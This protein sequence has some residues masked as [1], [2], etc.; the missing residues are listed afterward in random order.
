MF[1]EVRNVR[2]NHLWKIAA[3]GG[4]YMVAGCSQKE[5]HFA[6]QRQSSWRDADP[7]A[8]TAA[9]PEK[10][11]E[12]LPQTH[13]AAAH[14]FEKQGNMQRAVVQ[15]QKALQIDPN[16]LGALNRLGVVYSRLGR[17]K[18]AEAVLIRAVELDPS[19]PYLRNN[20]G[21][22][23]V[24]QKR[25]QDAEA[26]FRNALSLKPDFGRARINMGMAL[27]R[28]DRY[29]DAMQQF[30]DVVPEPDAYYNLGLMMRAQGRYRDAA[31]SFQSALRINPDFLA[32]RTQLEQIQTR[33]QSS[34]RNEKQL[35][36]VEWTAL[37]SISGST[38]A[39]PSVAT[40]GTYQPKPVSEPIPSE[41][42]SSH[43]NEMMTVVDLGQDTDEPA[44]KLSRQ[45][46][47]E[48]PASVQ[49]SPQRAEHVSLV[50]DMSPEDQK[51]LNEMQSGPSDKKQTPSPKAA[52]PVASAAKDDS[53][54][55][56]EMKTAPIEPSP[57]AS[58]QQETVSLTRDMGPSDRA[59]LHE[60]SVRE[61]PKP[62]DTKP[63]VVS[64]AIATHR[65]PSPS[66]PAAAK[67]KAEPKAEPKPASEPKAVVAEMKPMQPMTAQPAQQPTHVSL[68]DDMSAEDLAE[69]NAI[70][71]GRS[72]PDPANTADAKKTGKPAKAKDP[73]IAEMVPVE[74]TP[75]SDAK[76]VPASAQEPA[77]DKQK[78]SGKGKDSKVKGKPTAERTPAKENDAPATEDTA[79]AVRDAKKDESE[80]IE[81]M[82]PVE[83]SGSGDP[84]A[85]AS[86]GS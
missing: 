26:E 36:A 86:R 67:P 9:T 58:K 65:P 30:L 63:K 75:K 73:M 74:P 27:A 38:A 35:D 28:M 78:K 13:F 53:T 33:L 11:P 54:S 76:A 71:K 6:S 84:A 14:L 66:R 56:Q 16:H 37:A 12:I 83:D 80:V 42:R 10:A 48:T 72:T 52:Q 77:P 32:A 34:N 22:E 25:W 40:T 81:S 82:H 57:K 2:H 61:E 64:P 44:R 31:Q 41:H 79:S 1:F 8:V 20:L 49:R 85:Q 62:K 43:T 7:T 47:P 51:T 24:L 45:P 59:I 5:Q 70:N 69:L 46:E 50:S 17:H 55:I 23:Y 15:Y 29:H 19:S 4:L 60:M 3:L 18:E 21:F 39:K 68:V